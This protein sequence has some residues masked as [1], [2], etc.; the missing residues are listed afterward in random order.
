MAV[1]ERCLR[2]ETVLLR[3]IWLIAARCDEC[4]DVLKVFGGLDLPE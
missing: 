2:A 4:S 3:T 1:R